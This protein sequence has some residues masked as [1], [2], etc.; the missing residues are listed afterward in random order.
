MTRNLAEPGKQELTMKS[1]MGMSSG[2]SDPKSGLH[3][4][5]KPED[6]MKRGITAVGL[7][8]LLICRAAAA[9]IVCPALFG[10]TLSLPLHAADFKF[11]QFDYPNALATDA[12]GINDQGSIVGTF[13]DSA[14]AH[15]YVLR[16]GK[17]KAI[18]PPGSI[19]TVARSISAREEIVG[20]YY[21]ASFNLHGFYYYNGQ[22]RTI[23]IPNSTE[24]RAEGISAVGVISGEY[25]DLNGIEHGFL[26]QGANVQS[27]DVPQA[28]S[29]DV[30]MVANNGAF[31]GDSWDAS[32]VHGFLSPKPHVFIPLD[33]PGAAATAVRGINES[34]QVVGRWD[35][36]SVDL[37]IVCSIQCHGFLWAKDEFHSIDVPGAN[38]T[39]AFSLNNSG[40]IVG[41]FIDSAG[42]EHGYTAVRCSDSG[43][44]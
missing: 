5:E 15:G 6:T 16:E 26:L 10:L 33:F 27:I 17:F 36:Y 24:T 7:R 23:D 11:T 4:S 19:F 30:W 41:A 40:R 13:S 34:T 2:V 31:A 32:T 1:P 28:L 37:N 25:V 39:L 43:C 18:D 42:S 3:S 14:T 8:A 21:D 44:Q 12:L 29:T 35:D 20:F 22:F 38:S 9:R